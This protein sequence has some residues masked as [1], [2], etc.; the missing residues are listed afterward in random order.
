MPK[1]GG[2]AVRLPL[3]SCGMVFICLSSVG[4][5]GLNGFVGELLALIGMFRANMIYA[6][7]GATGII[8][9]AWYLLSMLQRSFFGPLKEPAGH[10]RAVTDLNGREFAA[11]MPIVVLCLWIGIYPRPVLDTIRPDVEALARLYAGPV[12]GFFPPVAL[13]EANG[14]GGRVSQPVPPHEARNAVGGF[15]HPSL[16]RS[17]WWPLS[18]PPNRH[19]R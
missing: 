2:L 19:A 6:V 11:L 3:L 7:V 15:L 12:E 16:H 8:L 10:G 9:G 13:H 1:L 4:L 17:T 5:P 18:F 14:D